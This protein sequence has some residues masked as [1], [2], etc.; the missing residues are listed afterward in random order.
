MPQEYA[1]LSLRFAWTS[2]A[3]VR[4]DQRKDVASFEVIHSQLGYVRHSRIWQSTT[5]TVER[6]HRITTAI[7]PWRLGGAEPS[8]PKLNLRHCCC[9]VWFIYRHGHGRG[10][11][12]QLPGHSSILARCVV[13]ETLDRSGFIASSHRTSR[14]RTG[15]SQSCSDDP[16]LLRAPPEGVIATSREPN[17]A[18]R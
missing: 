18:K 15:P 1:V 10:V 9:K 6:T 12:S 14:P 2:T 16:A 17:H 8:E 5:L 3:T 11:R 7:L 13:M 4:R